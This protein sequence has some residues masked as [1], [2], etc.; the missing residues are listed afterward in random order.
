MS[1]VERLAEK[2]DLYVLFER[3]FPMG[4]DPRW[5]LN[6]IADELETERNRLHTEADATEA[7][8]MNAMLS[9]RGNEVNTVAT[10]LRTQAE[11][12]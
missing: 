4:V 10:W 6:A 11:E 7:Y 8:P 3:K 9:A 5:W 2:W 12:E 1:L